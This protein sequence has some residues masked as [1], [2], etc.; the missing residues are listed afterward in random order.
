M[1]KTK[2]YPVII[3]FCLFLMVACSPTET[4]EQ[5][6]AVAETV[7]ETVIVEMPVTVEV[8]VETIEE[9]E[10]T[11][12]IET[13]VT[14][15]IEVTLAPTKTPTP[16]PLPEVSIEDLIIGEPLLI[17]GYS[18][19]YDVLIF[20]ENPHETHF[21][22]SL[23][24]NISAFDAEGLIIATDGT[25]ESIPPGGVVPVTMGLDPEDREIATVEVSTSKDDMVPAS[26]YTFKYEIE[27]EN[28][29]GDKIIGLFS[30][31]GEDNSP[32][33]KMVL[34]AYDTEGNIVGYDYTYPGDDGPGMSMPFEL[35]VR[36]FSDEMST[37]EIFIVP[38]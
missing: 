22:D 30:N 20:V 34:V 13:E 31:T 36:D 1:S 17:P 5:A 37:Y 25:Y 6:K 14:R 7:R 15:I 3:S 16:E 33:F 2:I 32:F 24:F 29:V 11:R 4:N 21:V 27:Q 38:N 23:E 26:R 19:S 8:T 10:V 28:R 9:I 18:S 35:N 12:L